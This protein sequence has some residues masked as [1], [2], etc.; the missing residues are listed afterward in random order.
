MTWKSQFQAKLPVNILAH[1]VPPFATRISRVIVD[2]GGAWRRTWERPNRGGDR[3]STISLLGCSTSVALA[4]G[5]TDEEEEETKKYG[6]SAVKCHLIFTFYFLKIT[7]LNCCCWYAIH[8]CNHD[9]KLTIT[10]KTRNLHY[11]SYSS[12]LNITLKDGKST[13]GWK[14]EPLINACCKVTV[15]CRSQ[16]QECTTYQEDYRYAPHDDVWSTTNRI[17]D[18]GP[19]IL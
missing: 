8:S 12:F 4:T 17:Y 7:S 5:P 2:V 3:L 14:L 16:L 13:T 19:I 11:I 6:I 9:Q 18:S 1:I 15:N 10:T